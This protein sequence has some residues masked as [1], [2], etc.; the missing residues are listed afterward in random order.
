M[1]GAENE[2][3]NISDKASFT[4]WR[5]WSGAVIDDFQKLS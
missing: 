4:L 1:L 3:T 2:I 5:S